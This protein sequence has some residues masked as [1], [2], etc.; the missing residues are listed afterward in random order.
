MK[1]SAVRFRLCSLPRAGLGVALL[2][3]MIGAAAA[4]PAGAGAAPHFAPAAMSHPVC[5]FTTSMT[6]VDL[7]GSGRLDLVAGNGMSYDVSILLGDGAGGFAEPVNLPLDEFTLG[8]VM[9]AAGDVSGDGHADLVVTGYNGSEIRVYPGDGT[10]GFAEP[11]LLDAGSGHSPWAVAVADV[12]SDGKLD[13]VT[14]NNDAGSVSVLLGDGDGGFAAALNSPAGSFPIALAV[15]DVDDDGHP[16]VVTANA[17]GL[18]VSVLHG[19]G[20]GHFA[21]P[22][23]LSIGADAEPRAVTLADV[24]GDGHPDIVTAN[25]DTGGQEFPPPELPGTVSILVNDG[26]GSFAPAV[27]Y[28]AGAGEGRAESVAVADVTGDGAADIVVSRPNANRAAVLAGDGAGG[29]AAALTLP[30]GVGP[31]PLVVA[32][33][34]GDGKLD[35]ATANAVGSTVSILPGDGAGHVGFDGN[36]D[37]GTYPHAV[38]AVDLDSDGYDDIVTANAFGDD[39]SVLLNDGAGGFAPEVRH[40]VGS[41]PTWIVAG[42]IDGDGKMD[43]ATANFGGGTVSVLLGDGKGG[44]AAAIDSGVGGDWE[45]PYALAL[46]DANGD[47]KLDIATANTNISNESISFL[48]GDGSGHFAPG[49]L[50]PTT[51]D[52]FLQDPRSV[53]LADVTGDG[54]ADIVTANSNTSGLALLVGDG[55]GGF[56]PPVHPA[57]DVGPV[58]VMAADVTGDGKTDLVSV[59]T[60]AQTVSVLAGDGS[61]GFADPVNYPIYPEQSVQDFM[62]WPWRMTLADVDGDGKPDIVTANTQNDTVSVLPND[63]SG[64]FGTYFN[65][66]TGAHPGS[67]AVAD[68]DG[69]GS[70]DVITANRDNNNVSVLFNRGSADRIF[71]DGFEAAP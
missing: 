4:S 66:D 52:G 39:V 15:A 18:D 57:T 3:G 26:N 51:G 14:A 38:V 11:L 71:A 25:A 5:C 45:S 1:A 41:S 58:D 22:T 9:V 24:D 59:N 69:D 61:G 40:A 64:G 32:D 67:V 36:H 27:Q 30:V 16:D 47:G 65:F 29:F 13:I 60:T 23:N 42:D 48:A 35:V 33:L 19:D 46:G 10:G 56:A 34:T 37:A 20:S 31:T 70:L 8:R 49:V 6:A 28:S 44:F 7:T 12:D 21:A 63:G 55:A 2:G 17:G 68:V 50:H 53:L 54:N 62:P 43:V